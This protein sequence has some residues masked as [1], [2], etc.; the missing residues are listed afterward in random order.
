MAYG[1]LVYRVDFDIRRDSAFY[2]ACHACNRCCGNTAIR[3]NPSESLRLARDIGISQTEC[4]ER[5]KEARGR[6]WRYFVKSS[7]LAGVVGGPTG[8]SN[9]TLAPPGM[10]IFSQTSQLPSAA[11]WTEAAPTF[12][13]GVSCTSTITSS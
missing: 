13:G 6:R 11:S 5:H 10:Q 3:I 7:V 8:R 9:C 2:Y 1:D 4:I 12:D